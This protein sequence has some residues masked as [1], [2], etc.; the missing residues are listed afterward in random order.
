LAKCLQSTSFPV[1][2]TTVTAASKG[3][4]PLFLQAIGSAVESDTRS[5]RAGRGSERALEVKESLTKG[6]LV[7]A[8]AKVDLDAV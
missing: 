2:K 6:F 3:P 8:S 1:A 7:F 4:Q 5:G